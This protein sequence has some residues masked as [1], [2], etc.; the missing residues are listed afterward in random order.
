MLAHIRTAAIQLTPSLVRVRLRVSQRW[1][2]ALLAQRTTA[3]D[4]NR[5]AVGSVH[6]R[7]VAAYYPQLG[8]RLDE[9]A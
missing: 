6:A 8:H 5:T 7:L 4:A 1:R 9:H 3:T 2:A